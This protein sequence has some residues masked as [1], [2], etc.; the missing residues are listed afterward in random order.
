MLTSDLIQDAAPEVKVQA[1]RERPARVVV[2]PQVS[3]KRG[4]PAKVVNAVPARRGRPPKNT[5]ET[6]SVT[7]RLF[8]KGVKAD[9]PAAQ[10]TKRG[11]RTPKRA[12]APAVQVK[13]ARFSIKNMAVEYGW[14][15]EL[16]ARTGATASSTT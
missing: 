6:A 16:S 13:P 14:N 7:G 2:S 3:P 15:V 12:I 5:N 11:G 9:A 4:R 8:P 1:H 10:V